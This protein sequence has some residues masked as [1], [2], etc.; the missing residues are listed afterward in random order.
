MTATRGKEILAAAD[1]NK[2]VVDAIKEL[3]STF[4]RNPTLF[5]EEAHLHATFDAIMKRKISHWWTETIDREPFPLLMNE[6]TTVN[7]Y[8]QSAGTFVIQNEPGTSAGSIDYVVMDRNWVAGHKYIDCVNKTADR[9]RI[10]QPS[11]G[12]RYWVTAEFKFLH[13]A[14]SLLTL[15]E[16]G[17]PP[18]KGSIKSV[19]EN[20]KKEMKKGC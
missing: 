8:R 13:F 3:I 11:T 15:D 18:E 7:H 19:E 6:Y 16:Q 2:V 12:D 4:T 14:E 1:A 9:R 20:M 10:Y 5:L 17:R